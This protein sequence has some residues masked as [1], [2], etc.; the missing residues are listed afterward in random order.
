MKKVRRKI[1]IKAGSF[2]YS[3]FLN[4]WM[5]KTTKN[6]LILLFFYLKRLEEKDNKKHPHFTI[7]IFLQKGWKTKTTKSILIFTILVFLS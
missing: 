1:Q 6:M 4:G 5:T 7:L 3:C 2:Y